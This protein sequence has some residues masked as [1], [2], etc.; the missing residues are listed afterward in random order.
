MASHQQVW[1]PFVV[2]FART[3]AS[4]LYFNTVDD[5]APASYLCSVYIRDC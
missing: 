3:L 2:A 1:P 5:W 4:D